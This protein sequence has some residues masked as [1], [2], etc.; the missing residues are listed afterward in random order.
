ML[1]AAIDHMQAMAR[2]IQADQGVMAVED[3]IAPLSEVFRLQGDKELEQAEQRYL[4]RNGI[5]HAAIVLAATRGQALGELTRDAPKTMVRIG[6]Q[7]ILERMAESLRE[8]QVKD[9]TVVAGYKKQ[10]ITL[11]GL[12]LVDNPAFETTGELYSLARAIDHVNGPALVLFGDIV[13]NRYLL[14]LLLRDDSDAAIVVDENMD[15]RTS[16]RRVSDFVIATRPNSTDVLLGAPV[17]LEKA[18]WSCPRPEFHGEWPGL[19][20]LSSAGMAAARDVIAAARNRPDFAAMQMIDLLNGLVAAGTA[21]RVHYIS[22][23][24]IDVDSLQDLNLTAGF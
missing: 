12:K 24:W 6:R 21:V 11:E 13:F 5:G 9:I 17:F 22:G 4:A 18:I 15:K 23:H 20:K 10:A 14:G 16:T 1:R 3:H 19:L 7:S 2:R 8:Y